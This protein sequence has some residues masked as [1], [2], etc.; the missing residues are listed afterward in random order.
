MNKRWL[1]VVGYEGFYEVS[2]QGH[3]RSVDR[4]VTGPK[5]EP[6]RLRGK[7]LKAGVRPNGKRI[8]ALCRHGKMHTALVHRLVL[9]AFVGQPPPG[10]E[11]CHRDDDGAN[12]AVEN[13]YWGTRSENLHDA[14]RNGRHWAA[15]K[16]HCKHGHEFTPANTVLDRKGRRQCGAC[17]TG[18]RRRRRLLSRPRLD[19]VA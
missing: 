6:K 13:L 9:L 4:T 12:N 15:N 10:T 11:S 7:V 19:V 1:P 16:T 17:R 5:G 2:D 3:V 18:A 14:V 8:V